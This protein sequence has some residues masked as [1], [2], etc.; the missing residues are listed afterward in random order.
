SVINEMRFYEQ[1]GSLFCFDVRFN[2][3][4]RACLDPLPDGQI[5]FRVQTEPG[6]AE[7]QLVYR[8]DQVRAAS[9][10]C[11]A[12]DSRFQYWEVTIRPVT[13]DFRYSLALKHDDGQ[14]AYY[15]RHGLTHVVETPWHFAAAAHVPFATPAWMQGAVMYQIFPERFANGAMGN[16]PAGT[17]PWGS[18]PKPFEFQGGDLQGVEQHLDYLAELGIDVIYFNPI[19]VSPSNHKYDAIDYYHVD[20]AFGGDEAL[21]ALVA[22]AHA[23]KIRVIVDASFNHCYPQFFAFRDLMLHGENSRYRDW[24]TV[25]EFPIQVRYRPH[26]L[27]ERSPYYKRYVEEFGKRSGVPLVALHDDGPAI[28]PT[29]EAWYGVIS[30]PQ[31]NQQN[32]ETRAYFLDVTQHWLR[33]FDVDGWRMDVVQFVADDFWPDFR[34]AAK[35]AKPDCYLLSEV[36]GDTSHW[37]QGDKFDATMNY[38]FRD[39]CLGY[40]AR[41]EMST[42]TFLEGVNRMAHL[43]PPQV[44]AVNQNLLSSHDV[45]RFLELAGGDKTRLKLA[46]FFQLTFPGA[47]SIYYGDEIGMMGGHDPDNRR[48]FPWQDR[49]GWDDSLHAYFQALIQLRRRLPALRQGDWR[50]LSQAGDLFAYLRETPEQRLLVLI[51]RGESAGEIQL[52]VPDQQGEVVF[53][54]ASLEQGADGIWARAVPAASGVVVRLT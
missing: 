37:L 52:R 43:Y 41:Q 24:F 38:L 36:W 17:V 12:R 44:L 23:R 9:F 33:E 34:Q 8:D 32:P 16:D 51:N 21:R 26:L 27:A 15:G 10:S 54:Q 42:A 2:P 35:V 39:L 14:V 30:M 29:Y 1:L 25:H 46:T 28:E 11:R 18:P 40:F 3:A 7:M 31:L 5:R 19:N 45:P 49:A 4:E 22:A 13:P 6:F 53:G 48:A 20:P 47:A 50:L